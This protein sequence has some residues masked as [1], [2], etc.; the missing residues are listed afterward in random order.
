MNTK[1]KLELRDAIILGL[2]F[3]LV[4]LGNKYDVEVPDDVGAFFEASDGTMRSGIIVTALFLLRTLARNNPLV[5]KFLHFGNIF[6]DREIE[7]EGAEKL[8]DLHHAIET[9]VV[10][11]DIASEVPDSSDVAAEIDAGSESLLQHPEE[12]DYV[13]W[14]TDVLESLRQP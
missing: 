7:H 3:L 4:T 14:A 5:D 11:E 9:G 8:L 13:D 12:D 6:P 2:T 1:R 10:I